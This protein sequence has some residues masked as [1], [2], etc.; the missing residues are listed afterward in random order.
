MERTAGF[1]G[2]AVAAVHL[3]RTTLKAHMDDIVA[4]SAFYNT[5]VPYC[6]LKFTLTGGEKWYY[7][8]D[9][10]KEEVVPA[11]ELINMDLESFLIVD[12]KEGLAHLSIIFKPGPEI[13]ALIED[14]LSKA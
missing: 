8:I 11:N 3:I 5:D 1:E 7:L 13:E 6:M 9:S 14:Y 4:T 12:K 2:F 10:Q